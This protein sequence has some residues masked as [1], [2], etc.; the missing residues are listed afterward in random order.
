MRVAHPTVPFVDGSPENNHNEFIHLRI[1]PTLNAL[2]PR[3]TF[4][5]GFLQV[6][7]LRM[8]RRAGSRRGQMISETRNAEHDDDDDGAD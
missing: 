4:H 1:F 2:L 8:D 3:V 6:L 5:D 7:S